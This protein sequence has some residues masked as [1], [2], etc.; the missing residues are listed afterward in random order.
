MSRAGRAWI[1]VSTKRTVHF[2]GEGGED[3]VKFTGPAVIGHNHFVSWTWI[4]EIR[5]GRQAR[6][7]QL[8]AIKRWHD[9]REYDRRI[10]RGNSATPDRAGPSLPVERGDGAR[11]RRR[12]EYAPRVRRPTS[13][14]V[15]LLERAPTSRLHKPS[16]TQ[17]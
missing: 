17:R 1:V 15:L 16:R 10:H 7:Q 3:R 2:T 6:A 9:N 5:H 8:R 12:S 13:S 11:I 14:R 4:F